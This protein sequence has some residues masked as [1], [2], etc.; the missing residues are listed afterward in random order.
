MNSRLRLLLI[1]LHLLAPLYLHGEED[2]LLFQKRIQMN[3]FPPNPFIVNNNRLFIATLTGSLYSYQPGGRLYPVN[4]NLGTIIAS[5]MSGSNRIMVLN[6]SNILTILHPTDSSFVTYKLPGSTALLCHYDGLQTL[7]YG[8]EDHLLY[9]INLSTFKTLFVHYVPHLKELTCSSNMAN[10]MTWKRT[11]YKISTKSGNILK[12]IENSSNTETVLAPLLADSRF[13]LSIFSNNLISRVS[14]NSF[15]I[16]YE[17]LNGTKPYKAFRF[18]NEILLYAFD[19]EILCFRI[20]R[21]RKPVRVMEPGLI[22]RES[23]KSDEAFTVKHSQGTFIIND[24]WRF[25]F[26][27]IDPKSLRE[28]RRS[29]LNGD[30][31][32]DTVL[33]FN[34][35]TVLRYVDILLILSREGKNYAASHYSTVGNTNYG[36][37]FVDLDQDKKTEMIIVNESPFNLS[38]EMDKRIFIPDIYTIRKD[39]FEWDSYNYPE[40]YRRDLEKKRILAATKP[41]KTEWDNAMWA[42]SLRRIIALEN[43]LATIKRQIAGIE[44][45]QR[46]TPNKIGLSLW[47]YK[48]GVEFFRN[49]WD[50]L[51]LLCFRNALISKPGDWRTLY[52]ISQI[53]AKYGMYSQALAA[54]TDPKSDF[55][56]ISSLDV[57]AMVEQIQDVALEPT[58]FQF[59]YNL[60]SIYYEL[61]LYKQASTYLTKALTFTPFHPECTRKLIDALMILNSND[62]RALEL[63]A[64]LQ[65]MRFSKDLEDKRQTLWKKPKP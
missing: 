60:G 45:R 32:L 39:D 18:G 49:N 26:P 29:D 51:A 36:Q 50:N 53:Y 46:D 16:E 3:G 27:S 54:F 23:E 7:V 9:G 34:A 4:T 61:G 35:N 25:R 58:A 43:E 41:F 47:F 33:L 20:G 2:H 30:G 10:A 8:T 37:I 56:Y 44:T 6:T 62:T 38:K 48:K 13:D 65:R 31:I 64:G 57:Y 40:Y 12:I 63:I 55:P 59:Q 21:G 1:L 22:Y 11:L 17:G 24:K 42:N 19:G 14:E 5:P 52:Q 28:I 15:A